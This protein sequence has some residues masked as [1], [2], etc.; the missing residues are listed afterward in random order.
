MDGWMDERARCCVM[1]HPQAGVRHVH[2]I[3]SACWLFIVIRCMRAWPG[4]FFYLPNLP[5]FYYRFYTST[6]IVLTGRLPLYLLYLRARLPP[7]PGFSYRNWCTWSDVPFLGTWKTWLGP[8][9]LAWVLLNFGFRR[10]RS[11]GWPFIHG[12]IMRVSCGAERRE[13]A[14]VLWCC[15][16]S[17]G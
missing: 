7:L 1:R 16:V 5:T 6:V 15:R 14:R 11:R 2:I 3:M 8:R 4:A 17:R 13:R 10:A 9:R 12:F